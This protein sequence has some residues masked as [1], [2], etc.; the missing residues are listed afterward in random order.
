[1]DQP[2]IRSDLTFSI[3]SESS[4]GASSSGAGGAR[5]ACVAHGA[6]ATLLDPTTGRTFAVDEL[7][8]EIVRSLDGRT[9]P[10]RI[11][12]EVFDD[13]AAEAEV[14]AFVDVLGRLGF[15]DEGHAPAEVA[16][17]QSL[18]REAAAAARTDA[19]VAATVAWAAKAIPF[20]RERLGDAALAIRGARDLPALPTM[21]KRDVRA[22]FPARLLPEGTTMSDLVAAGEVLVYATSG[23][24]GE[25]LQTLYDTRRHGYPQSFPGI[26][27]VVGGWDAA[28]I[29][30]F[31][32]P[33]CSGAVCHMGGTPFEERVSP[34]GRTLAVTSSDHPM[35]LTRSELDAILSDIDRYRPTILRTDPV[36]AVALVRALV[37][38]GLPIPRFEAI[39]TAY[40]YCSVL[41]RR[42]LEEAFG[43]PVVTV[44]AATDLGGGCQAF[45]CERGLFHVRRNQY[46]FEFLRGGR[47]VAPGEVG[48]ITV[49]SLYH[50]FMPLVRYRI[51][52]LGAPSPA[53]C[54]CPHADWPAF[55]L[56]GRAA[57]CLIDTEGRIVTTRAFDDLFTGLSW[58]D[59]YRMTQ[60]SKTAF[61]LLCVRRPDESSGAN[62]EA[63]EAELL[64]RARGLLGDAAV[65]RVRYAREIPAARSF[66]YRLTGATFDVG[67]DW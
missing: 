37:R 4:S 16:L 64:R 55:H 30:L 13:P 2:R 33:I 20:Y 27:P 26:A 49:T 47:P 48:E 50:R 9:S 40:E 7:Q 23:T 41:H 25:R 29:A 43:V 54:T 21:S 12:H 44:F 60:S 1:M 66:K 62:A 57:D 58:I 35:R 59:F 36:Y 19:K 31:T 17:R 34:D 24:T 14:R 3:A 38:E 10:A 52:D 42:V 53:R 46:V 65:V 45:R 56:E 63:E 67:G 28:R 22:N 51:E 5:E 39:W 6:R 61:E 32:T 8:L 11:A 15:L 18:A